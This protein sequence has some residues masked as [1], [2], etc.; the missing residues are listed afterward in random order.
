MAGLKKT[1]RNLTRVPLIY[2]VPYKEIS[3]GVGNVKLWGLMVTKKV[4][5]TKQQLTGLL[6]SLEL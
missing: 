6:S 4:K 3:S 5:G 2:G 1:G